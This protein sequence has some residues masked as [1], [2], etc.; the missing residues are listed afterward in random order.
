MV[1]KYEKGH[2]MKFTV[3]QVDIRIQANQT[4]LLY[5]QKKCLPADVPYDTRSGHW[6]I[7][8]TDTDIPVGFAGL[9]RSHH[10]Y[11][12]GYLCRAGVLEAYTGNGIQRKLIHV[13]ERKAKSLNWNWLITDTT[14]N[15]ASSNS[16]I[17]AGFKLYEPTIPWA[18][19]HSLYWRKNISRAPYA[20]Q[21]SRS[22][23]AKA[24]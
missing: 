16:L 17:N 2:V 20:L 21:R 22:K 9:V 14:T 11:D 8:Y 10:W 1:Y 7:A 12:C 5:L 13:R 24:S 6:W 23:K 19:K 15:P 4:V 3:K 18:Y